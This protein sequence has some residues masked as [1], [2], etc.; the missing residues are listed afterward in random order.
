MLKFSIAAV[1]FLMLG[2]R[3]SL[4]ASHQFDLL[5]QQQVEKVCAAAFEKKECPGAVL[6][7][8]DR[9]GVFFKK[10]YGNRAVEPQKEVMTEDTIFDLASLS[11]SIGCGTS[12]LILADQGKL[13]VTDPVG[14][15]LPGMNAP[16]KKAITIEMCLLHRAGFVG[17]NSMKD[18]VGTREEMLERVYATKLKYKPGEDYLYS[19]M[20]MIVLGEVV[21]K[22]SGEPLDVF[23]KKNIYEPLGMTE[24]TYNPPASW[25]PRIAP[26]EKRNGQFIIGEVHDPRSYAL[27]GVA[28]HA[29]V[30]STA[31]DIAKWCRMLL[32]GGEL[33]G[34]RILKR[35]TVAEMIR[36]R[37]LPS[38]KG[39]RGYSV[40]IINTGSDPR[41][42]T[43]DQIF[44]HTGWT[45]TLY[46]CDPKTGIFYVLLT[47]RVH[48]DG[49]GDVADLRKK[50]AA[51]IGDALLASD[52]KPAG[53]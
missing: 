42:F 49:K 38:G 41:T 36:K 39:C 21:A 50:I 22:V 31:D 23:A 34:K 40:D 51:I 46:R 27:G 15:Y 35:E 3:S 28:G 37:C 6:L 13:K 19:D 44:G 24:T 14:K 29:G 43:G 4:A 52:S 20:S 33:D 11:K 26:T 47:N 7:I 16:D 1:V 9:D 10:A 12:I 5:H 48:P 18:Y 32:N 17:D 8:G 2:L 30:F 25:K 45:G 53:N